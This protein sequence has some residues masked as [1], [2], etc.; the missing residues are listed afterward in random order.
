[1]YYFKLWIL[2]KLS[3]LSLIVSVSAQGLNWDH[4]GRMDV[5]DGKGRIQFAILASNVELQNEKLIPIYIKYDPKGSYSAFMPEGWSIPFL[6]SNIQLHTAD[7]ATALLPNGESVTLVVNEDGASLSNPD[8]I[9]GSIQGDRVEFGSEIYKITYFKGKVEKLVS[10]WGNFEWIYDNGIL[11]LIRIDNKAIPITMIKKGG[12]RNLQ[13]GGATDL[14][15]GFFQPDFANAEILSQAP[16][17]GIDSIVSKLGHYQFDLSSGAS[18]DSVTMLVTE[19]GSDVFHER[20]WNTSTGE[21]IEYNGEA[22]EIKYP[23]EAV[24]T[25]QIRRYSLKNRNWS[26]V[27]RATGMDGTKGVRTNVL[28]DGRLEKVYY[29][30]TKLGT[31]V[32]KIERQDTDGNFEEVYRA[33]YDETGRL[34]RDTKGGVTRIRKGNEIQVWENGKLQ[35]AY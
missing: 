24:T 8:G 26:V 23:N 34:L 30:F 29:Y 9:K 5:H 20:K 27:Q 14:D 16:F 1:M 3:T 28:D 35:Y 19:L 10:K 2:I 17:L 12:Q 33:S 7:Y 31:Q 15:I 11:S 21:I 18:E 6:D 32:R 22:F 13:L 4:L 25:P